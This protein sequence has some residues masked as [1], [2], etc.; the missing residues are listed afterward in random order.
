MW[1]D[2]YIERELDTYKKNIELKTLRITIK[3]YMNYTYNI[4]TVSLSPNVKY[5][6]K[7]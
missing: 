1:Y 5:I 3:I 2:I 6:L 4:N 7:W